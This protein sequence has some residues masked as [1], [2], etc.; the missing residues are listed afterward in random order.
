MFSE[1]SLL[2]RSSRIQLRWTTESDLDAVLPLEQDAENRLC[3]IPWQREQHRAACSHPDLA[4][5]IIET[6]QASRMI[7]FLLLAGR[8][9]PHQSIE[10]RRIVIADKGKG[11]GKEALKLVKQLVFGQWKAHRLWLDVFDDNHR[12]RHVYASE[13]FIEE[14]VLR[15]CVSVE[16]RFESLVV[17]S[18]LAQ[19]YFD[20]QNTALSE[21]Y[22]KEGGNRKIL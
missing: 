3:I 20:L 13:G 5:L 11:Y 22:G 9:S 4:H 15:E 8:E 19:E 10:F 17:M 18:L 6:R 1:Q 2:A 21:S 14:G 16:G 7:G 12:A